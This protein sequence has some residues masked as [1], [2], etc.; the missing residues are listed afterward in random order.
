M[1][2]RHNLLLGVTG[3]IAAYKAAELARELVRNQVNVRVMMTPAATR[4]VSPLTFEAL[5]DTPVVTDL[6]QGGAVGPIPHISMAAQA[7]AILIAPASADSL[8][9]I[10]HGLADDVVSCTVMAFSGPLIVAPAMHENMF[11]HPSTQANIALLRERG[12]V[13]VGPESG[14][15]ASGGRGAGRMSSVESLVGWTL[16]TLGRA[17][18]LAGKTVV[19]TA[20][21]TQEPIDPVRCVTN[22]SSG[23]M[24]YALAEASRNRGAYVILVTAPT[25][26]N[27]PAGVEVLPVITAQQMYDATQHA[28][29]HADVL[30][31]AAAVADYR[32][33][34]PSDDKI[35]KE[36][37]T[38]QL[39][40]E[41]T[42]DIL[43]SLEG[44]FIRVGFAAESSDLEQNARAKL[45]S[46]H[47]HLIVANDITATDSG[48]GSESNRVS[49]L[50]REGTID[51][52]P[53]LSK[54]EVADRV[55]DRVVQLLD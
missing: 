35:K 3:S 42:V 48:F 17:G 19:V 13:V 10:A 12:A 36:R 41:R 18:D 20:G 15:L 16:K 53:L 24:G 46:K 14:D 49:I 23:K 21:G 9:R 5:L 31:M 34:H 2:Q 40:L 52:L 33:A 29:R 27:P 6:F 25:A 38:L 37:N 22:R 54:R 43:G 55:L 7:D 26:L 32:P 50:G 11:L 1:M 51:R 44:S 8:A 28:V 30:V 4:F 39:E 47:L 45:S